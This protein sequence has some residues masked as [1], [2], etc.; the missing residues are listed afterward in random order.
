MR[1]EGVRVWGVIG[2]RCDLHWRGEGSI[3]QFLG[4]TCSDV[5]VTA[6]GSKANTS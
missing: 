6:I 5:I 1:G 3:Q 2:V 4:V